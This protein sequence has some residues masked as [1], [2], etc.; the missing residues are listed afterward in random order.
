MR[1]LN[2]TINQVK[3]DN[4][5]EAVK[6]ATVAKFGESQWPAMQTI[7]QRE[8]GF[9]PY[10]VN[11]TSGAAGLFQA[12]PFSKTGCIA[13][14]DIDCQIEWGLNYVQNRYASPQGALAF[15]NLHH[16]Y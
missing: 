12:L 6:T 9:N 16:W 15:W 7:I 11:T 13:L 5:V 14:S 4:V 10:A 2:I 8:S 3:S 1:D